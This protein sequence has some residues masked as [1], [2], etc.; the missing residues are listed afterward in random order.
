MG[1][2]LSLLKRPVLL[3][4]SLLALVLLA[5]W[6]VS[7]WQASRNRAA[8]GRVEAAQADAASKAGV[9]AIEATRNAAEARQRIEADVKQGEAEIRAAKGSDAPVSVES[10]DAALRAAC[11]SA[12]YRDTARCRELVK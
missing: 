3:L 9:T 12:S 2:I 7:S 5:W 11:R 8:Q 4:A 6:A 10:R 1:L